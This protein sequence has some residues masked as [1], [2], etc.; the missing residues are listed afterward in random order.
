VLFG[1]FSTTS[2]T[3][4]EESGTFSLQG[5]LVGETPT[6]TEEE[7]TTT[8]KTDKV[9]LYEE[10]D[11]SLYARWIG[12]FEQMPY[13]YCAEEFPPYS[14]TT[15]EEEPGT[16]SANIL[17]GTRAAAEEEEPYVLHPVQTVREDVPCEPVIRIGANGKQIRD[18]DFL[19]GSTDFVVVL[20]DDGLYVIEI[21]DRAWQNMQPLLIGENLRMHIE[22]GIIYAY[23]GIYIYRI[24]LNVE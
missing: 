22:N 24:L 16:Q 20:S 3:S 5:F 8:V 9:Q 10:E 2:S 19:P 14:T 18:F 11:G 1:L 13:Y 4:I 12:S 6:T 7:A 17:K 21:D 23:D 15:P